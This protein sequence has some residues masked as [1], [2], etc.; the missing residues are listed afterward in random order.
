M[1]GSRRRRSE[2][3]LLTMNARPHPA[4]TINRPAGGRTRSGSGSAPPLGGGRRRTGPEALS[5]GPLA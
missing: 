3:E 5:Q 2:N 4:L 1:Q